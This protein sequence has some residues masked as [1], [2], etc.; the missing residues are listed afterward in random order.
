[1]ETSE[2]VVAALR[3]SYA[4]HARKFNFR[5][6]LTTHLLLCGQVRVVVNNTLMVSAGRV[7]VIV[8]SPEIV[9]RTEGGIFI[10]FV[11]WNGWQRMS[12]RPRS[13][14]ETP[15]VGFMVFMKLA[16][17]VITYVITTVYIAWFPS[18]RH[19]SVLPYLPEPTNNNLWSLYATDLPLQQKGGGSLG[20]GLSVSHRIVNNYSIWAVLYGDD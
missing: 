8:E 3:P 15:L 4:S 5:T 11:S 13:L 14:S 6:C 19:T 10:L 18:T 16:M 17:V 1:M 9:R 7:H 12:F 2:S 20:S